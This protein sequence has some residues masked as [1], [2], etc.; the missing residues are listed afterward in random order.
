MSAPTLRL[1]KN[2]LNMNTS[3]ESSIR[4]EAASNVSNSHAHA[5]CRFPA[6][7]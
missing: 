6:S 4:C 7:N 1:I 3:K 5:L 2:I